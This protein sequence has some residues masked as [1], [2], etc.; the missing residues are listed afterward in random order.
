MSRAHHEPYRGM[1]D[2]GV[3][4]Y[5]Q[6]GRARTR[7]GLTSRQNGCTVPQMRN[8][9]NT[10]AGGRRCRLTLN[11][12]SETVVE[13]V[14]VIRPTGW[15]EVIYDPTDVFTPAAFAYGSPSEYT[16]TERMHISYPPSKILE[17][18]WL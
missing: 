8:W 3:G 11:D 12:V 17:I 4:S 2:L 9:N 14:A 7:E 15:V 16:L 13:T 5:G 6:M 1:P 10:V 18:V